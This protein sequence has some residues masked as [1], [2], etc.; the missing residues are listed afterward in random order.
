MT[1]YVLS[2][3]Q[4]NRAL[5]ARQ[6]LLRRHDLPALTAL[7]RV[8]GVQHQEPDLGYVGLWSRLERFEQRDLTELLEDRRAVR[9]TMMRGTQH[10]VA[11]ADFLAFRPVLQPL[12]DRTQRGGFG[13]ATAGVDLRELV[14][15]ARAALAERPLR[16]DEGR[17][18]VAARWPDHDPTA[19]WYSV[20][21]LLALVTVPPGATWGVRGRLTSA[22]AEAWLG[23]PLATDIAP[24]ELL[25]RYLAAFGPARV[26][27]AQAWSGLTRLRA[28]AE[29]LGDR[30]RTYRDPDGREVLDLADAPLPDPA[31][32]API[33]FLPGFDNAVQAYAD[34]SRILPDGHRAMVVAGIAT[35]LVDGEVGGSWTIA[36]TGDTAVLHVRTFAPLAPVDRDELT[37]EGER[38]LAFAAP[39]A[40]H[41]L[42]LEVGASYL[43]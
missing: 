20:Q 25:V 29:R 14:E 19:L 8:A 17:A 15:V 3:R 38:L 12:L 2:R 32:P 24:D 9:G 18:L 13:A 39:G 35:V 7:E 11:E 31:T 28:A 37:G 1:A 43:R 5:L 27:D 21:Y 16:G 41:D 10:V 23:R 30:L 33:R 4:L 26:M 34:R 6:L 22:S 40:R 42:R 36:R